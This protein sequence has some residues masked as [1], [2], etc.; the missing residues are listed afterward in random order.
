[1]KKKRMILLLLLLIWVAYKNMDVT[2][3]MEG[4]Q[5]G[6]QGEWRAHSDVYADTVV[7]IDEDSVRVTQDGKV[8]CDEMYSYDERTMLVTGAYRQDFELFAL[9]EYR[10]GENGVNGRPVLI[11]SAVLPGGGA[12]EIW[13]SKK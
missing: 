8:L 10:D 9:F 11:G 12:E 3:E 1:M 6:L 2:D 5:S 7:Y 13:F 4:V